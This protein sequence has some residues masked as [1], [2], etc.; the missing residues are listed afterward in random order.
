MTIINK[1][2][3][4]TGMLALL[5]IPT[6]AFAQLTPAERVSLASQ[7]AFEF[8]EL[9]DKSRYVQAQQKLS[10]LYDAWRDINSSPGTD[11]YVKAAKMYHAL[12]D[13]AAEK[14]AYEMS[15]YWQGGIMSPN[16]EFIFGGNVEHYSAYIRYLL[17]N[18]RDEDA[19]RLYYAML[20]QKSGMERTVM[21]PIH[22]FEKEK[23]PIL[24]VF[25]SD[26]H[27][28]SWSYTRPKLELLL[29]I[30]EVERGT[31]E[32]KLA[33]MAEAHDLVP[34]WYLPVA[35]LAFTVP[36]KVNEVRYQQALAL[37]PGEKERTWIVNYRRY[38]T[39]QPIDRREDPEFPVMVDGHAE[40]RKIPLLEAE[41]LALIP[42]Y[43][44]LSAG[45][46]QGK[47]HEFWEEPEN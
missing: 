9:V 14:R 2:H 42:I 18:D 11:V 47:F 27:A 31:W 33:V 15:L 43:R 30:F 26:P 17:R 7:R 10:E 45:F 3:I 4:A 20:R 37:A 46:Q 12:G 8:T 39:T 23:L 19:V 44:R 6:M 16:S 28:E 32:E 13:S 29:K 25:A 35:H 1:T 22:D 34:S 41:R 5:L 38:H 21:F 40:R 24:V 36:Y